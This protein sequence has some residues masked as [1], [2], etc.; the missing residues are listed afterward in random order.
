M[1]TWIS[2]LP[3]EQPE[4][5]KKSRTPV[6]RL[7]IALYGH[8]LSGMFWGRHCAE[9]LRLYG[10][11]DIEGWENLYVRNDLGLVLS[12]YVDD[13]KMAGLVCNMQKGWDII[14]KYLTL[15]PP[16]DLGDYLGCGQLGILIAPAETQYRLKF[17]YFLITGE[18]P[19]HIPGSE[20][21]KLKQ[22]AA[23]AAALPNAR[24]RIHDH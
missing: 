23:M 7:R 4:Y 13:F 24:V 22:D 1:D 21:P 16:T 12:V 6:C 19:P 5:W 17:V 9:K 20:Q 15:D 8:L 14:T 2:L 11:T 10:W 18:E 3:E